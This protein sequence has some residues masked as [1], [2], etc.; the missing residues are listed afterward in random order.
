MKISILISIIGLIFVYLW[1]LHGMDICAYSNNIDCF[2]RSIFLNLI[3]VF[4]IITVLLI[5]YSELQKN[6]Y[7]KS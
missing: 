3:A 7:D 2:D 6:L 5:Q 1:S 4:T